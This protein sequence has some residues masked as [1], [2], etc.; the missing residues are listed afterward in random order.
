MRG[1]KMK[2]GLGAVAPDGDPSGDRFTRDH[3]IQTILDAYRTRIRDVDGL[4]AIEGHANWWT[5]AP[6]ERFVFRAVGRAWF[7]SACSGH[8]FKFGALTGR[9]VAAAISGDEPA[10]V[11]E[12]RLAGYA[13]LSRAA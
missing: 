8:G 4:T 1:I 2:L 10:D 9:D 13:E 12:R 7:L 11:V 3:E 5:L 6:E